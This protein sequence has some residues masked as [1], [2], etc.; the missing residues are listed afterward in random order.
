MLVIGLFIALAS[1]VILDR[2][3]L[4]HDLAY[5]GDGRGTTY[6]DWLPF[7]PIVPTCL[8]VG[9][10][11]VG[12]GIE[13]LLVGLSGLYF[14]G[15]TAS[16]LFAPEI[17]AA[18]GLNWWQYKVLDPARLEGFVAPIAAT[19]LLRALC[20]SAI[21]WL[22]LRFFAVTWE[23][24][25]FLLVTFGVLLGWPV[26]LVLGFFKLMSTVINWPHHHFLFVYFTSPY[27][28]GALA[29]VYL[30]TLM[31][32]RPDLPGIGT[33]ALVA[34]LGQTIF[35]NLGFVAGVAIATVVFLRAPRGPAVPALVRSVRH[36][37]AAGLAS[38]AVAIVLLAGVVSAGAPSAAGSGSGF[39]FI[40]HVAAF[41]RDYGRNNLE[42]WRVL[43]ADA[44]S[45]LIFPVIFSAALGLGAWFCRRADGAA[46][47]ETE[48]RQFLAALGVMTGFAL[49][50]VPGFF[51]SG[52]TS[53]INRQM[54]PLTCIVVLLVA[55]GAALL[56]TRL[57]PRAVPS[58]PGA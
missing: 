2:G 19:I 47:G 22:T 50:L 30:L 6:G 33:T 45:I 49:S 5:L 34:G 40:E 4:D 13:K 37:V 58:R 11:V 14:S 26:S 39:G 15:E 41:W 28:F 35:E 38:L 24:V 20:M 43:V 17:W 57:F 55:R 29:F 7:C 8:R 27:D 53:D 46:G 56:L 9:V 54:T 16:R 52:M 31:L 25:V 44:I 18:Q 48:R 3:R 42:W 36:L 23:R 10:S 21:L 32:A 12:Y 1:L 51:V